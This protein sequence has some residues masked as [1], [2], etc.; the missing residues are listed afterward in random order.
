M[1]SRFVW[2]AVILFA[3]HPGIG[4]GPDDE[5]LLTAAE[6]SDY[7]KTASHAEVVSLLDGLAARY[8]LARRAEMGKT[9]EGRAIPMLIIADPPVDPDNPVHSRE[10]ERAGRDRL[11]V[12]AIGNIHA[13]E[14]DGKEALPM[15]ARQI[16]ES[17]S[18]PENRRLL[19]KL[20]IAFAPIYNADGN[21]RTGKGHR[22]GQ[23]GP[24][25]VGVRENAQGLDLNRDFI[26]VE[27]PE[28]RALLKAFNEW[29]P[30]IFI[31][32]HITN[33]SYHRYIIT[34]AG[35]KV[36]A[37]DA[38]IIDYT[39]SRLFPGI[40]AG[41]AA[42]TNQQTYWYGNFNGEWGDQSELHTRWETFP[43]EGRYGTNYI[44]LRNRLSVLIETY[45]YAPYKDRVAATAEFVRS[46]L[47][48]AAEHAQEI[49]SLV[50]KADRDDLEA[51]A[52]M[53]VA[54][55]SREAPWP[56]KATILGY[57][58][59]MKDGH[60]VL[61]PQTRDY[62]VEVWDKFEPSLSVARPAAYVIPARF[63]KAIRTIG[64]H[65]IEA[66]K[67]SGEHEFE[68]EI[69]R[70]DST[71][72]ASRL[73]QGHNLVKIEA[74]ARRERCKA[75]EGSYLVLTNQIGGNLATYLLE[76]ESE[77]GLAVWN[78]FDDGLKAG[79]D[80]PVVRVLTLPP[81]LASTAPDDGR[82]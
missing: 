46:T 43:A 16:L 11:V 1:V 30:A 3:G 19:D 7:Q 15:L 49:R 38:N 42:R 39:R 40:T 70:I 6:R 51:P 62:Q 54:I 45:T 10:L 34:Y 60:R 2:Y 72:A 8:P 80:F 28:T 66:R 69:Y 25:E 74:T 59:E 21:E 20:I 82:K 81:D 23:N 5:Q 44:G 73:F 36:P 65:G 37:G 12:M 75:S 24:E 48:Y 56:E 63:E 22:I 50:E 58:E 32:C 18:S 55:R 61:T 17:P 57:V 52:G 78:F 68:A 27:A 79:A 71:T 47:A 9:V 53:Q 14:V 31:D 33:G 77:D 67:L 29:D 13:G 4:P 64:M 76:P 35:A 41:F 26:K